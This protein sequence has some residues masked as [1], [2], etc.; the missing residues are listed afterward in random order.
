MVLLNNYLVL[1]WWKRKIL[2]QQLVVT[3]S[4]ADYFQKNIKNVVFFPF[5]L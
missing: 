4:N 2:V 3:T 1:I 5:L